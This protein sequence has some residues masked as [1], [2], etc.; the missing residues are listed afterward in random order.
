[1]VGLNLSLMYLFLLIFDVY[2]SS[3]IIPSL[4]IKIPYII[5]IAAFICGILDFDGLRPLIAHISSI[6]KS[7]NYESLKF[8]SYLDSL[9]KVK[10]PFIDKTYPKYPRKLAGIFILIILFF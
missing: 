6:W 7:T 1:M 8:K 3:S 4:I 10:I 5:G 9:E 2:N